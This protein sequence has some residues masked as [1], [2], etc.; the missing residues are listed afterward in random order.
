LEK[1]EIEGREEGIIRYESKNKEDTKEMN[2][3][4]SLRLVS[5]S[6]LFFFV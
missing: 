4:L 3:L 1:G 6:L 2:A 5:P